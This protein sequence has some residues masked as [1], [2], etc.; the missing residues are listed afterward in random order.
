MDVTNVRLRHLRPEHNVAAE[1]YGGVTI[2]THTNANGTMYVAF[3]VCSLSDNFSKVTGRELALSRLENGDFI[4]IA[5][6]NSWTDLDVYAN[7]LGVSKIG[8]LAAKLHMLFTISGLVLNAS[9]QS[10]LHML[11]I[12]KLNQF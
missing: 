6:A 1:N 4:T 10:K 5:N 7:V 2:A 12:N 11:A 9:E 3:A 8:K